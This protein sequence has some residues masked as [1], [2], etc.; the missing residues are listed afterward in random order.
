MP[1]SISD[2]ELIRGLQQQDTRLFQALNKRY[3]RLLLWAILRIIPD[4]LDAQDILQDSLLKIW[5]NGHRLDAA[6]DTLLPWLLSITR[7]AAI[8]Y[9]RSKTF[10]QQQLTLSSTEDLSIPDAS[11]AAIYTELDAGLLLGGLDGQFGANTLEGHALGV[12][13]GLYPSRGRSGIVLTAGDGENPRAES[14]AT[15]TVFV[16][17]RDALLFLSL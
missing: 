4:R 6:K 9:R 11:V 7:H 13:P 8:D 15:T 3:S 12:F 1:A 5:Q 14:V 2:G 17:R 10:R 16:P